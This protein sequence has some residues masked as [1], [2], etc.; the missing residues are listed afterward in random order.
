MSEP[1]DMGIGF[2]ALRS[3]LLADRICHMARP[4]PISVRLLWRSCHN[5]FR[6]DFLRIKT[7]REVSRHVYS[8]RTIVFALCCHSSDIGN[9]LRKAACAVLRCSIGSCG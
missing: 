5:C 6:I 9:S 2:T 1:F 3:Q 7:G 4:E 8:K